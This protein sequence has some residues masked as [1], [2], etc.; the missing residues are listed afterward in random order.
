M[1]RGYPA[2]QREIN[3]QNYRHTYQEHPERT[4]SRQQEWPKTLTRPLVA[5]ANPDTVTVIP[6][7]AVHDCR[8]CCQRETA[9]KPT[10]E[11]TAKAQ[12]QCLGDFAHVIRDF[13]ARNALV[14]RA[15][16]LVRHQE[17]YRS[18]ERSRCR[19]EEPATELVRI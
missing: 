12:H 1:L 14:N 15:N 19:D 6:V 5:V 9:E 10:Y 8:N 2:Q 7:Q 13:A 16:S 17:D 3:E 18:Q 4:T 11:E